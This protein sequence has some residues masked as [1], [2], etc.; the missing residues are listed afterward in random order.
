M[1][2][3]RNRLPARNTVLGWC[4]HILSLS[5]ERLD[6]L[7]SLP[8]LGTGILDHAAFCDACGMRIEQLV[9]RTF[10]QL[11]IEG[12]QE[13]DGWADDLVTKAFPD[14]AEVTELESPAKSIDQAKQTATIAV[15][16]SEQ[17][18]RSLKLAASQREPLHVDHDPRPFGSF[19]A[20]N[21]TF[22]LFK[23]S[24]SDHTRILLRGPVPSGASRV[25]FGVDSGR[26]TPT[27]DGYWEVDGVSSMDISDFL[28]KQRDGSEV[29][30]PV[31]FV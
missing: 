4:A 21:G 14:E 15:S 7:I 9:E 5:D 10:D 27:E 22:E 25:N 29:R 3:G 1:E 19:V 31:V 6:F 18:P 17:P 28:R 8:P 23:V 24:L 16:Q 13:L 26:L 30:T 20:E 11:P 12:R 2:D